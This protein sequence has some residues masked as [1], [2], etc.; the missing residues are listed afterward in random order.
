MT[1]LVT[2][3]ITVVSLPVTTVPMA[4]MTRRRLFTP[5]TCAGGGSSFLFHGITA[6]GRKNAT[7]G[8]CGSR[9]RS[10]REILLVL[11]M[12]IVCYQS[13][14]RRGK[15]KWIPTTLAAL[16][17]TSCMAPYPTRQATN[18]HDLHPQWF[19]INHHG[20]RG[21][22]GFAITILGVGCSFHC[23]CH[24]GILELGK[25]FDLLLIGEIVLRGSIFSPDLFFEC[26][27]GIREWRLLLLL[28]LAA[29]SVAVG[30]VGVAG[31]V[32]VVVVVGGIVVP[33]IGLDHRSLQAGCEFEDRFVFLL[34]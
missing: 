21:S 13:R 32:V 10:R 28:I 20:C 30:I 31:V 23:D 11:A 26:R 25:A 18:V 15:G 9:Y 17:V 5:A 4:T 33:R 8:T 6:F 2:T 3:T 7:R 14:R 29:G 27:P 1:A 12:F 16:P 22:T 24:R 19:K 34:G